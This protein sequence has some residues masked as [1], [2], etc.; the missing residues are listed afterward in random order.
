MLKEI[1]PLQENTFVLLGKCF[2]NLN[3]L[4]DS[5]NKKDSIQKCF[6]ISKKNE[7]NISEEETL[8]NLRI[9]VTLDNTDY[10]Q[11]NP[12]QS[13]LLN[14]VHNQEN[15]NFAIKESESDLNEKQKNGKI[16]KCEKLIQK[17]PKWDYNNQKENYE[18]E[19]N[20]SDRVDEEEHSYSDRKEISR[21]DISEEIQNYNPYNDQ[22][23]KNKTFQYLDTHLK[24]Q[25]ND[26]NES[27]LMIKTSKLNCQASPIKKELK[28][29]NKMPN[30]DNH[31]M[32]IFP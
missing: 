30:L 8:L 6:S 28:M 14:L 29:S 21:S 15:Q 4:F 2:I 25:I 31:E 1:D 3:E 12:I 24:K 13:D 16:N 10:L 19:H 5:T 27:D 11:N 17:N 20:H 32:K 7:E 18:E 22:V 23:Q 26:I 9:Q